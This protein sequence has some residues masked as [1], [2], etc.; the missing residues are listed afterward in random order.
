[1]KFRRVQTIVVFEERGGAQGV[2]RLH[3]AF[4]TEEKHNRRKGCSASTVLP[5][6]CLG[7]GLGGAIESLTFPRRLKIVR[8]LGG[9]P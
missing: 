3:T 9:Q 2:G 7:G 6:A 4:E 8:E 1:M 5:R